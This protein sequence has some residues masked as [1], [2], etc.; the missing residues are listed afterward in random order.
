MDRNDWRLRGQED[1]LKGATLTRRR[2]RRH[3]TNPSSDHDHCDFC[4]AKFMVEDLPDVL[5]EGYSTEDEYYW[6]C[7]ACYQDFKGAFGWL[8]VDEND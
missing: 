6:V 4:W 8:V 7:P 5:H 3:S 2:Y 1:Y